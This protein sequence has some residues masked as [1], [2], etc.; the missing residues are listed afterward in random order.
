M[1]ETVTAPAP[2]PL[3]TMAGLAVGTPM[4][5]PIMEATRPATSGRPRVAIAEPPAGK[6]PTAE[7]IPGARGASGRRLDETTQ[8][9]QATRK[10]AASPASASRVT[11]VRPTVVTTDAVLPEQLGQP[12]TAPGVTL[13]SFEARVILVAKASV[14]TVLATETPV[15]GVRGT[16]D[17][18]T[19]TAAIPAREVGV[20][21][22]NVIRRP[23][24]PPMGPDGR[25][26]P[27]PLPPGIGGAAV[28]TEA[29]PPSVA[30]LPERVARI[31]D[32]ATDTPLPELLGLAAIV[33]PHRL[34][35]L[36]A[37]PAPATAPLLAAVRRAPAALG[38][39]R[40]LLVL[41]QV[42][43]DATLVLARNTA[44]AR[45]DRS[46]LLSRLSQGEPRGSP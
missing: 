20:D 40:T 13:S 28:Q 15:I 19:A 24:T 41:L 8:W 9:P 5:T 38:T 32:A 2:S 27:R 16:P 26:A 6:A 43:E 22:T 11:E 35:R 10:A 42:P 3:H 7:T 30:R 37:L 18:T 29:A 14:A 1:P 17:V 45:T 44:P 21:A 12:A 46:A 39:R 34:A 36:A 25:P 23:E 31:S 4:A 33:G